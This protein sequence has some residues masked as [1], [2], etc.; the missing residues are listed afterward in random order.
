MYFHLKLCLD[1]P[2]LQICSITYLNV[3]LKQNPND[4]HAVENPFRSRSIDSQNHIKH[5]MKGAILLEQTLFFF[6]FFWIIFL[7]TVLSCFYVRFL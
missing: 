2:Q 7:E 3:F 5:Q 1:A 4:S 6:F